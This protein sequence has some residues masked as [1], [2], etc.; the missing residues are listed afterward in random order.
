MDVFYIFSFKQHAK[1]DTCVALTELIMLNRAL[2]M[3]K[4]TENVLDTIFKS[5][6]FRTWYCINYLAPHFFVR[7]EVRSTKFEENNCICVGGIITRL[8]PAV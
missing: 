3:H 8:F 7:V 6:I 1:E 5:T 4:H 2:Q